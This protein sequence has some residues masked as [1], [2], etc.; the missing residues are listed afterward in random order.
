MVDNTNQDSD[1]IFQD[2]NLNSLDYYFEI[3]E[4][5]F[6]PSVFLSAVEEIKL[7]DKKRDKLEKSVKSSVSSKSSKMKLSKK[8]KKNQQKKKMK[9]KELELE[10]SKKDSKNSI[11][12]IKPIKENDKKKE[13][14][15]GKNKLDAQ[16]QQIIKQKVMKEI[17]KEAQKIAES[18]SNNNELEINTDSIPNQNNQNQNNQN[19]THKNKKGKNKNKN[20][21]KENNYKD[22]EI[23]KEEKLKNKNK[24]KE[25]KEGNK[26]VDD[27]IKSIKEKKEKQEK[28]MQQENI[29]LSFYNKYKY[30]FTFD[31]SNRLK[32]RD[33]NSIIDE[34]IIKD[35]F[36]IVKTKI[37]DNKE[38]IKEFL[39]L[40]DSI[41]EILYTTP[42]N[43]KKKKNI[44]LFLLSC[45]NLINQ[46]IENNSDENK[47]ILIINVFYTM[48]KVKLELQTLYENIFNKIYK[49]IN[50]DIII[51]SLNN[52]IENNDKY[53]IKENNNL[54][55]DLFCFFLIEFF[56]NNKDENSKD[57]S[58]LNK[59]IQK[60]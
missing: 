27:F 53:D 10:L 12:S 6:D 2:I 29:K 48:I 17:F 57:L 11:Y 19:N 26:K 16:K 9:Q 7:P 42:K 3:T 59:L 46:L 55:N 36:T 44:E 40:I 25:E 1:F 13:K 38:L 47:F 22:K 14:D 8:A 33:E 54:I 15:R 23:E 34:D 58:C 31:P 50:K 5:I 45:I 39:V 30:L 35:L 49:E 20:K 4:D 32:L 41:G 60:Y 21:N 52:N 51:N 18:I 43:K 24:E 37:I 28:E 56:N